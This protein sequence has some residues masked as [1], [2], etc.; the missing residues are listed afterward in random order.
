MLRHRPLPARAALLLAGILLIAANLRAPITGVAPVLAMIQASLGLGTAQAGLV[1]TLPLLAFALL[2]PVAPVLA[3][4]I[5]LER[6]LF[7]ALVLIGGGV[8]LR[9]AGPLGCLYGGTAVIGAGIALGN[10]LLPSLL[11]R[12]FPARIATVTSA[13][14]LTMG[15]AAAVASATVFP[16]ATHLG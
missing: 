12:D 16:L 15:V 9:S 10:V 6:A 13:Y 7:T 8:A 2:S 14:A 1:T 4:R 3:R 11:K 5:G